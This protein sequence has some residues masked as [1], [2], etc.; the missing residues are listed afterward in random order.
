M[1]YGS[2]R[3]SSPLYVKERRS[4]T[5]A[6]TRYMKQAEERL[7]HL[8]PGPRRE[9]G[10]ETD[11]IRVPS[12]CGRLY[13][14]DASRGVENDCRHGHHV[15]RMAVGHGPPLTLRPIRVARDAI[16]SC[17]IFSTPLPQLVHEPCW[18]S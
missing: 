3:R 18:S 2:T 5:G 11:E 6:A 10:L 1:L 7:R 12:P 14:Q 13:Q 15:A 4:P 17:G 9:A 8:I 16:S